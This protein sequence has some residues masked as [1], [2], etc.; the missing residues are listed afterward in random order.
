MRPDRRVHPRRAVEQTAVNGLNDVRFL[1]TDMTARARKA[2]GS[3]GI[4]L[5]LGFYAWL[6]TTVGDHVPRVWWAQFPY[7][8]VAGTAWGL[9]VI[10]LI[11][12]MNRGR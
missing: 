2:I 3:L 8:L 4:L 9:P 5:F 12:W 1:E 6:V 10:P 7:Y 11:V